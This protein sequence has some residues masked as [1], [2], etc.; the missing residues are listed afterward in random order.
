MQKMSLT[1]F[2]LALSHGQE[3]ESV[4]TIAFHL[5]QLSQLTSWV[6][7]RTQD[8]YN[9]RERRRLVKHALQADHR[10]SDVLLPHA[11]G[12][13]VCDGSVD[14]IHSETAEQHQGLE[15]SQAFLELARERVGLRSIQIKPLH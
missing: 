15:V 13:K 10:R 8:E 7:S 14:P 11:A 3:L 5:G 6:S 4:S 1:D 9:G 2:L 12:D